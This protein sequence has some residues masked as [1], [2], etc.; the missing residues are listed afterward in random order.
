MLL[1][2]RSI[3]KTKNILH[4]KMIN[5]KSLLVGGYQRLPRAPSFN[6]VPASKSITKIQQ[7]E[8]LYKDIN[9]E[10]VPD[11][12]DE[13][14]DMATK[15]E[16]VTKNVMSEGNVTHNSLITLQHERPNED[17][18]M[19]SWP[20]KQKKR[21]GFL[22]DNGKERRGY[23][24]AEKMKELEMMG[25]YD[26]DHVLDVEEVL[27]HYSHLTCPAYLDIVDKFFM[28]MYYEFL[29]PQ[30]SANINS[31]MRRLHSVRL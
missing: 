14:M 12:N 28:D 3:H 27:H 10:W 21:G 20:D 19:G 15:E 26:I 16:I 23:I 6:A 4:K 7:L 24:I 25:E 9:E 29:H 30:P 2:K 1:I 5:L 8:D 31:S 22:N 17:K 13:L 18:K 11:R